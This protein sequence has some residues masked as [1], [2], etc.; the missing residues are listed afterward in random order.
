MLLRQLANRFVFQLVLRAI[1]EGLI[2][3]LPQARSAT[4]GPRWVV[5]SLVATSPWLVDFVVVLE[6]PG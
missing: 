5:I 4:D 3:R 1:F 6:E 2:A